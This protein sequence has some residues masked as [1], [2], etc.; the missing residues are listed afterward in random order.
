MATWGEHVDVVNVYE[1]KTNL[2]RL[3][4]R[5]AAGEEI[6]LARNGTPVARL[7]PIATTPRRPGRLAGD[8]RVGDD[9]D[10]PLPPSL[11]SAFS[12]RRP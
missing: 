6:L 9:F 10:D 1:A 5:V 12:G 7:C 8:L 2:S 4:E 11:D 3:L